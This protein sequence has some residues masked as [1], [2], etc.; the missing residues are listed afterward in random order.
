MLQITL[1]LLDSHT[2]FVLNN[3]GQYTTKLHGTITDVIY[4]IVES[5]LLRD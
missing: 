1:Q 4:T 3:A 2:L 5:A